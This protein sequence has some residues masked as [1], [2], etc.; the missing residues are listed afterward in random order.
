MEH[1]EGTRIDAFAEARGLDTRARVA[2]FRAVCAAVQHA[3]QNLVVHRDLKPA[4]ILVT[5]DGLPKL[6]DFGVAKLLDPAASS[7]S[8]AT[9]FP[10]MTPAYASPEQIKG[11]AI[12]TASDVY[13]LGTVLYELLTGV[14]PH[15]QTASMPLQQAI[16]EQVPERPSTVAR[17]TRATRAGGDASRP[18]TLRAV[19]SVGADLDAIV[20][21]ALRK[22]PGRRYVTVDA[23]SEDLRRYLEGL[24]V[25]A[26][27]G[28]FT[29]RAGKFARRNRL[30]VA[31][32][33]VVVSL[34]A[35]F[36]LSS[37]AQA[38]RVARERDRAERVTAFLVDL[39]RLADPGESRGN[40]VTAREVLDQGTS[41]LGDGA[42][43][44]AGR[45]RAPARHDRAGALRAGALRPR[46]L[47]RAR[48]RCDAASVRRTAPRSRPASTR[49]ARPSTRRATTLPPRRPIERRSRSGPTPSVGKTARTAASLHGVALA[50][51]GR[52]DYPAAHGLYRQ[53]L[54]V[55]RRTLGNDHLDVARTLQDLARLL[56]AQGDLAGAEV[57]HR[58]SL[59]LRRRRLGEEHPMV[60]ASL[61][62]LAL[63]LYQQGKPEALP[64]F[65]ETLAANRRLL[66]DAH[67]RVT[68]GMSNL[69]GALSDFE[70][71]YDEAV[72]LAA[73]VVER[74]RRSVG[75]DH[76]DFARVLH[77]QGSILEAMGDPGA[78]EPVFREAL[79]LRRRRLGPE[80][81]SVALTLNGLATARQQQGDDAG[82]EGLLREA[83]AIDRKALGDAH[84]QTAE[85]LVGL[86]K[87]LHGQGRSSEAEVAYREALAYYAKA[88]ASEPNAALARTR[89]ADLLAWAA[90]RKADEGGRADRASEAEALARQGLTARQ[91]V[92]APD[93][94]SVLEATS[95]LGGCVAASR[96]FEE[97]EPLLREAADSLVRRGRARDAREAAQRLVHLYDAW[98]DPAR[99]GERARAALRASV[100]KEPR[101]KS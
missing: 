55:R 7:E 2:L 80:H 51:H 90:M 32:G 6:L 22:E 48:E 45:A 88:G 79:G 46:R 54:A 33:I 98:G 17:T 53:A 86:G 71:R 19:R 83:L 47:A 99:A 75:D 20:M 34:G 82:A 58:E 35:S 8:T 65:R 85:V 10:A 40:T 43:R 87:A 93:H 91:R 11:E 101:P 5:E 42:G 44:P 3:H 21:K 56:R 31:L 50:V 37:L 62:N 15:R 78:A 76:P 18:R 36:A 100:T 60:T 97:A 70:G 29:Y 61:N 73:E 27:K 24:P 59:A 9:A 63:V 26:A 41:R 64:L 68:T 77:N 38:R 13:S 89:L 72:A 23:L 16:C 67:P 4:N 66:G 96:R 49:W 14:R 94:P 12:T 81:P 52:G 39:F 57:M 69:A 92:Q 25:T 74:M 30:T 84:P 28:T 1:V 95:V